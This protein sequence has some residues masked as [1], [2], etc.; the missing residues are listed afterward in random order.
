LTIGSSVTTIGSR[1][2]SKTKLTGDIT[3]PDSV[4]S[5]VDAFYNGW[6]DMGFN[7]NITIGS[8]LVTIAVNTF[9]YLSSVTGTL[10]IGSSVATIGDAAF[11]ST[12][13]TGALS[14]PASVTTCGTSSFAGTNFSTI[15]SAS[16]NYPA[17]D[18]VLYDV[19]TSGKVL[20]TIG[21]KAYSGTLTLRNDTTEIFTNCFYNNTGRTGDLT[22]VDT[23]T[24]IGGNAFYGC[25][26]LNGALAIGS[27]LTTLSTAENTFYN[28]NFSTISSAST[29][30]PAEDNVLYDCKTSGQVQAII[31]AK[32]YSGTLT[33]KTG[34]TKILAYCFNNNSGRTGTLTLL[35]TVT[36]V[37]TYGFYG[38]S[39]FTRVDSYPSTAPTISGYGMTLGGTAR[40]L[41][42]PSGTSSYTTA[43]WTTTSIFSSITKDL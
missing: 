9:R 2:F 23:L 8:G 16:T 22:I 31:S 41:H 21:A 13:L 19:K 6:Y 24:T 27:G 10:A 39:G 26:G 11:A 32:G 1:V 28:T 18:N 7:G 15:S 5:M 36:N 37:N 33:L 14:L 29:N 17:Y 34:T 4:T 25:S 38:C 12:G 20:A 42:V 35:S 30:Y 43:P 3:I 40:R